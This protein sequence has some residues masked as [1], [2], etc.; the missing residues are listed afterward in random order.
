MEMQYDVLTF[1]FHNFVF[2]IPDHYCHVPALSP[3]VL[4]HFKPCPISPVV[5]V[6]S[7]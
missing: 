7:L 4:V 6:F 3:F 2:D 5:I 1:N